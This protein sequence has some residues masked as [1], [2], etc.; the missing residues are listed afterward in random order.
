M[1]IGKKEI[2]LRDV[3]ATEE[4]T[5]VTDEN[6]E[7]ETEVKNGFLKKHWKKIVAGVGI[8]AA[9]LGVKA[10]LSRSDDDDLDE[11]FDDEDFDEESESVADEATTES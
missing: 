6:T 5:D 4:V 10:I 2:I 8:G 9:A 3:E 11:E 7:E 1:K